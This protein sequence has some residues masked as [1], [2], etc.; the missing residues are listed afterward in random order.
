VGF[1]PKGGLLLTQRWDDRLT[2]RDLRTGR[3]TTTLDG[4]KGVLYTA[5]FSPD[6][7]RLATGLYRVQLWD[8]TTGKQIRDFEG[9]SDYVHTIAFA[10][11]GKT[12]VTIAHFDYDV[13]VWDT[14]TGKLRRSFRAHDDK[15]RNLAF[16]PDGKCFATAGDLYEGK[17]K[18]PFPGFTMGKIVGTEIKFWDPTAK[19]APRTLRFSGAIRCLAFSPDGKLLAAGFI[20][21]KVR[22]WDVETFK[23]RTTLHYHEDVYA[24][25]FSPDG[26]LLAV[27]GDEPKSAGKTGEIK[28]WKLSTVLKGGK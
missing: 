8:T 19:K 20:S 11:D 21:G 1:G 3:P 26:K 9:H 18:S 28:I 23:A 16:A 2:L 12:L 6:G 13:K 7:K 24:V 5:S 4:Y 10:P 17:P 27:A 25:A 22:L 15:P 14:A